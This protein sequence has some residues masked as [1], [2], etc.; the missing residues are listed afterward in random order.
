MANAL[1]AIKKE[2]IDIVEAKIKAFQNDGDLHFPDHYSPQNALKSAWLM[3]Q[4]VQDRNKKPALEVCARDS[5]ANA[6]LDMVVQGLSPAKKQGYFIVYGNSLTFMRSYFGT[7]A[8]TQRLNGVADVVSEIIYEGDEFEY[9]IIN[10]RKKITKHKQDFENVDIA[11]I[12][13]VYAT[14]TFND[15]REPYVEIMNMAQVKKSWNMGKAGDKVHKEYP[16]QMAK[17][18]VINR[19]CKYF[20]N[21]SNDND[22]LIEAF[23]NSGKEAVESDTEEYVVVEEANSEEID[24]PVVEAEVIEPQATNIDAGKQDEDTPSWA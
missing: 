15:G 10:G 16:D 23:N 7:M 19:A 21:T 9:E 18:T 2:T 8:V 13:G 1:Q 6:L 22:L 24:I 14:I 5:V 12:K 4:G 3:L 17:R 11:K 20:A